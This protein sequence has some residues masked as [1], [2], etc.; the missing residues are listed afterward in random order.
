MSSIVYLDISVRK[1][2]GSICEPDTLSSFQ[3]SLDRHLTKDL[4][5]PFSI[6]RDVQFAS[7]HEKLKAARKWLKSQGKGNKP[8]AS[9]ALE[10]LDVQ[11]LWAEGGLRD[12][13]LAQLQQTIWWL[14]CTQMG[15]RENV[16]STV[17]SDLVILPS[18]P[19]LTALSL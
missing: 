6:I 9:E 16:T 7:S 11:K 12:K 1:A 15:T 8:H 13:D 3:R 19:I 4:H 10:P 17:S 2:D 5:K 14:I 18:S